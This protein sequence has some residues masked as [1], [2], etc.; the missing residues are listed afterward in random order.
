MADSLQ[1]LEE[2][3]EVKYLPLASG[4]NP[5]GVDPA[6]HITLVTF[7]HCGEI[8]YF[9]NSKEFIIDLKVPLTALQ[10]YD[11]DGNF[12]ILAAARDLRMCW[13][14]PKTRVL[15]YNETMHKSTIYTLDVRRPGE[16]L[17]LSRSADII[18]L[19]DLQRAVRLSQYPRDSAAQIIAAYFNPPNGQVIVSCLRNG[20]IKLWKSNEPQCSSCFYN[21]STPLRQYRCI[22]SSLDGRFL[23]AAGDEPHLV[24]CTLNGVEKQAVCEVVPLNFAPVLQMQC[25]PVNGESLLLLG[26]DGRL[27]LLSLSSFS[28]MSL[29]SLPPTLVPPVV[30]GVGFTMLMKPQDPLALD[31]A[32]A[33]SPSASSSSLVAVLTENGGFRLLD[34]SNGMRKPLVYLGSVQVLNLQELVCDFT[35]KKKYLSPCLIK[36][37]EISVGRIGIQ[38]SNAIRIST[39]YGNGPFTRDPYRPQHEWLSVPA[40]LKDRT[41]NLETAPAKYEVKSQIPTA[42]EH[43]PPSYLWA[44]RNSN[45]VTFGRGE[46]ESRV[47]T[48]GEQK[49]DSRNN[50]GDK[51]DEDKGKKE[52]LKSSTSNDK[53]EQLLNPEKLRGILAEHHHFP[54]ERRSLLWCHL[55]RLRGDVRQFNQHAAQGLHPLIAQIPDNPRLCDRLLLLDDVQRVC[56][57]LIHKRK[58]LAS[59][60]DLSLIVMPFV[61]LFRDTHLCMAYE[62]VLAILD[63]LC[64]PLFEFYPSPPQHLLCTMEDTLASRDQ[65]VLRHFLRSDLS[66]ELCIWPLLRSL[67]TR[68]LAENDWLSLWDH[69][70]VHPPSFLMNFAV[71]YVL[72]NRKRIFQIRTRQHIK[73]FHAQ[74]SDSLNFVRALNLTH[75]LQKSFTPASSIGV[76]ALN[77]C[78]GQMIVSAQRKQCERLHDPQEGGESSDD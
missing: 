9:T 52:V 31:F 41:N 36:L 32:V 72:V 60:P 22:C 77:R 70:L 19:W 7:A 57:A 5:A 51:I 3:M 4:I 46:A 30:N 64:A 66:A 61:K 40:P 74:V 42:T 33:P 67:F 50:R 10:S 2:P 34:L 37:L 1:T 69:T 14:N 28:F 58:K 8:T 29:R 56:S 26:S 48:A 27:R 18:T 24:V 55:L 12:I 38:L 15:N 75:E 23:Y 62:A 73:E 44:Q 16:D 25:V 20:T 78:I 35:E 65:E 76:V 63:G 68:V 49:N 71:A 59:I 54:S 39:Y 53:S 45:T 21:T 11:D 17:M 47:S 43:K 13:I 6:Y